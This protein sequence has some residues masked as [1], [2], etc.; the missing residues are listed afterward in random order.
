MLKIFDTGKNSVEKN[1]LLDAELLKN[2]GDTPI[3]HFYDWEGDSLTYG[4]FLKPEN[5][6]DLEELKRQNI[7]FA[8]RPTGGGIVFHIWD[9]AFSYLMPAAHPSFSL[10]PLDNYRFV[11]QIVL[12][13][14][15]D[16]FGSK[17]T[18]TPEHF[19]NIAATSENFCMARPT[20]YDVIKNGIKIAGAAQR[21]TKA[22]YLHQGT[23]SL[24]KP[25]RALLIPILKGNIELVDAMER[26]A[27]CPLGNEKNMLYET[28]KNIQ[29]YLT[30]HF[31]NN[32]LS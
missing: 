10:N 14:M 12:H 30:K 19:P 3:L 18:L 5:F 17:L 7:S 8:R 31:S 25:D 24:V 26:H 22:G 15:E 32:E 13:A 1:M 2:L 4:Y 9:L 23:I 21:L 16:C 20:K 11:N 6:L 29:N 28:R 27:F